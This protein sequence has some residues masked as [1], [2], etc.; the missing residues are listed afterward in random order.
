MN[1]RRARAFWRRYA[2]AL[3][4]CSRRR[5]A[6]RPRPARQMRHAGSF[7]A[8]DRSVRRWQP[9]P[10]APGSARGPV[11]KGKMSHHVGTREANRPAQRTAAHTTSGQRG[12]QDA[13]NNQPAH[14]PSDLEQPTHYPAG[15]SLIDSDTGCDE[16]RVGRTTT[17]RERAPPTA[18]VL[19]TDAARSS[20]PSP[21]ASPCGGMRGSQTEANSG[22]TA[23]SRFVP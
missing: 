21:S 1:S 18:S 15:W 4:G 22:G 14:A 7:A 8:R 16:A 2:V 17:F 20:P 23:D 11:S 10:E 3:R 13:G 5:H 9:A 19:G 6:G 12:D